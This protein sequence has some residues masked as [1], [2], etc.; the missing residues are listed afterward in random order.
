M[1]FRRVLL[2]GALLGIAAA[3]AA[4][5]QAQSQA[6]CTKNQD[7]AVQCFAGYA[8]KTGIFTLHYGMTATQFNSYGV[9]VSKIIQT[10][11]T[12]LIVFGMASAVADAMPPTNADG[13][14]NQTAQTNAMNAIVVAEITS[15]LIS[16]PAETSQ[17]Q[18]Q[19]FSLDM[20][21]AMDANK[22]ILM[23]PGTLL[24]IIDS[25]V[26]PQTVNGSVNWAAVNS[27]LATMVG[28]LSTLGLLKLPPTMTTAQVTAFAQSLALSIYDY[29]VTTGRAA[30]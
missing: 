1:I 27:N 15:G 23:S 17:Q 28:S 22:G 20:A 3:F 18:L 16:I 7:A 24:R 12:N 11:Q 13:T 4:P 30:L 14:A 26:V 19:W 10:S 2:T 25:Y 21:T 5:S 6:Q 29:K 9:A 8:L